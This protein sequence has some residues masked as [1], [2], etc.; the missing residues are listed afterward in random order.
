MCRLN[1]GSVGRWELPVQSAAFIFH[2]ELFRGYNRSFHFGKAHVQFLL[3][4]AILPQLLNSV[5]KTESSCCL[6]QFVVKV[7]YQAKWKNMLKFYLVYFWTVFP[8]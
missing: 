2:A 1:D 6:V 3:P 4:R 5:F 7:K 8:E